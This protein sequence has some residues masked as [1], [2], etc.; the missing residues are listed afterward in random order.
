QRVGRRASEY[1]AELPRQVGGVSQPGAETLPREGWCLV[2]S[3]TGEQH[4]PSPPFR[5]PTGLEPVDGVTLEAGV[6]G[7][8][9]PR[10]EESPRGG[11]VVELVDRLAGKRHELPAPPAG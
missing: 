3:V 9:V 8:G 1:E 4:A 5:H 2:G 6:A 10:L 7:V 11:L